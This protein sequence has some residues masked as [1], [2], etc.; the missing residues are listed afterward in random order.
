MTARVIIQA[1]YF[2]ITKEN[3]AK[4]ISLSADQFLDVDKKGKII[5]LKVILSD[6]NSTKAKKKTI[7][8]TNLP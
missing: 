7:L 2:Q 8:S 1:L 5:G 3:I 6:K 4:T